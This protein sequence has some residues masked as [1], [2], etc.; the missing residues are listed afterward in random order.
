MIVL[1]FFLT[2]LLSVDHQLMTA[3][4]HPIG[5]STPFSK[6]MQITTHPVE[7][8]ADLSVEVASPAAGRFVVAPLL[9]GVTGRPDCRSTPVAGRCQ[10]SAVVSCSG[11]A[12]G[13]AHHEPFLVGVGGSKAAKSSARL[14]PL[15][16]FQFPRW[17]L[18][19]LSADWSA[20]AIDHFL[21]PVS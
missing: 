4:M 9:N 21:I 10:V 3:S 16:G 5:V 11:E 2:T 19:L 7:M 20:Q 6:G 18:K 13:D 1:G 14:C 8:D 15:C 12:V 17:K